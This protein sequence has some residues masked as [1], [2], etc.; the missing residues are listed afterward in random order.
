MADTPTVV[1]SAAPAIEPLTD[2]IKNYEV[3]RKTVV[4]EEAAI[5]FDHSCRENATPAEKLA[6]A[7]IMRLKDEDRHDFDGAARQTGYGR[8]DHPHFPGDHFL[9]NEPL[10]AKTRLL[11]AAKAMPKGAHLHIHFNACLLPNVLLDIA[12]GMDRM[13]I[14]SDLPLVLAETAMPGSMAGAENFF[15]CEI[16]FS[17]LS[18]ANEKDRGDIFSAAYQSRQTM[19]FREFLARFP[20]REFGKSAMEWLASKLVFGA[21]ETY[22]IPQTSRG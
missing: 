18:K 19:P 17:I 1:G 11:A 16:Q 13:F 7:V 12:K 21:A 20:R 10:I 5:A 22:D 3:S 15:L 9:T 2:R 14:T 6:D 4:N 8:Q